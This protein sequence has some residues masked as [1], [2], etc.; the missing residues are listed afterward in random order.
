[1]LVVSPRR[2]GPSVADLLIAASAELAGAILLHVD[3]DFDLIANITGQPVGTL[4]G[5]TYMSAHICI[6]P[7]R[8]TNEGHSAQFRSPIPSWRTNA[9]LS[10][11]ADRD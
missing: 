8:V 4:Q 7:H 1:V 11:V 5:S 10:A 2:G 3:K 6:S 9:G